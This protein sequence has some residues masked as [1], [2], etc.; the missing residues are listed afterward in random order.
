MPS[1]YI[2]IFVAQYDYQA[3]NDQELTIS[4]GDVL[5]LLETSNE[6]DWWK[7]K[8]RVPGMAAEEPVGLVPYNYITKVC[9]NHCPLLILKLLLL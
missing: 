9:I 5:Y 6:D 7:V 4:Q 2:G 3:Q 8:K 1:L